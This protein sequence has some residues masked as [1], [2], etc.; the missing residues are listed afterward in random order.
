MTFSPAELPSMTT[1]AETATSA[2]QPRNWGLALLG[3]L[4]F[5]PA[6]FSCYTTLLLPHLQT[7]TMSRQNV[8]L[9]SSKAPVFVGMD[10]FN[11]LAEDPTYSYVL[12]FT[13]LV[14]IERVL[15]I[16]VLPIVLALAANALG[17]I[18]RIGT[19]LL[20]T[21]PL[22]LFAPVFILISWRLVLATPPFDQQHLLTSPTTAP[23]T[24]G[25]IDGLMT[26]G[27][28]C[29]VG[30][31]A[32][33]IALRGT[34]DGSPTW[35]ETRAPLFILWCIS[36]F[37]AI[38]TA[39][40]ASSLSFIT[41]GGPGRSTTS[42]MYYIYASAF[43][44]T[45]FGPGAAAAT[46]MLIALAVMGFL[47][48]VV[49]LAFG[50][51]ME[52]VPAN[53]PASTAGNAKALAALVFVLAL[54][55][56]IVLLWN[57]ISPQ[58]RVFAGESFGLAPRNTETSDTVVY[59]DLFRSTTQPVLTGLLT[60]PLPVVLLAAFGIGVLRPLG[61][62]SEWLL[63]PFSPWLY[64]TIAP[65]SLAVYRNLADAELINT[66][67]ALQAGSA[68]LHVPMLFILTLFF[69]GQER[70]FRANGSDQS[71]MNFVRI[72]I[73][74]VIPLVL[75]LLCIAVALGQQDVFWHL[76]VVRS[77][78]MRTVPDY[79]FT[80]L[81]QLGA[82]NGILTTA[83]RY[84]GIPLALISF[85]I[86]ALYQLFYFDRLALSTS[87]RPEKSDF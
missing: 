25:Y 12:S 82:L 50:L 65:L 79:L 64:V 59:P 53:K 44:S 21:I 75:L 10:N 35:R 38:A 51:R 17:R 9:L 71:F 56:G 31:I 34:G 16:A 81:S 18:A 19:R 84:Y 48:A 45:R 24:L 26:F 43:Q 41:A 40:Q 37:T 36:I 87:D 80:Q 85:A 1:H 73:L 15:A 72:V 27:L 83:L 32:Y 76:L 77:P 30:L 2:S 28:A 3:L 61:R 11:R 74:P 86:L 66:S 46:L 23:L 13:L 33:M 20:F 68:L 58:M 22:A 69:K 4:M 49:I 60:N 62:Y 7:V 6:V 63:L 8:S 54:L 67:T 70:K 55:I 47:T 52:T 29:G 14:I 42:M 39:L 78:D 5:L 57:D